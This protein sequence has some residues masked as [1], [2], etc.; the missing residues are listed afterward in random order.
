M[1]ETKQY[2]EK[3]G[4]GAAFKNTYKKVDTHPDY[5]GKFTYKGEELE[6]AMWTRQSKAGLEY[7]RFQIGPKFQ[8]KNKMSFAPKEEKPVIEFN[9]DQEIPF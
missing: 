7:F 3:D 4:A 5:T 9:D 2:Q 8:P 1:S 6:L